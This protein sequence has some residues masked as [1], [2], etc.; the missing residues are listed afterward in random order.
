MKIRNVVHKGLLR[1]IED[2]DPTGVQPDV[3][4]KLR[5]IVSFLQEMEEENE[6]RAV[7]GWKAHQ[8]AGD[9]KGSWSL[10]VTKNWRITFWID[11]TEIEIID[12]NYEDY[13]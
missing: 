1:L 10:L 4:T 12:L 6:L 3:V 7:P 11:R 2:D 8:L 5:R 9:R 13:H